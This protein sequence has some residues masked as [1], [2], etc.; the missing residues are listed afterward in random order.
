MDAYDLAQGTWSRLPD[1]PFHSQHNKVVEVDGRLFC[2]GGL[3]GRDGTEG[4]APL[5]R[6]ATFVYDPAA[7]T[8]TLGPRLP[9]EILLEDYFNAMWAPHG[10]ELQKQFCV[11]GIVFRSDNRYRSAAFVWDPTRETW[12]PFPAPPVVAESISQTND[13]VVAHG[14]I[15]SD[16]PIDGSTPMPQRLFVLDQASRDWVEWAIPAEPGI[17]DNGPRFAAVRIG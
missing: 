10:F 11:M 13:H 14:Y 15:P 3:F 12:D 2:F 16:V 8:W 9:H 17:I 7:R 6:R 4:E 5:D 1:L